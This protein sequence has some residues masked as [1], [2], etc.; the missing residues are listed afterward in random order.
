MNANDALKEKVLKLVTQPVEQTGFEIADI[1]LSRYRTQV[2]LRLYIYGPKGVTI[3]DCA[4]LSRLVGDI[5]D[6]TDLFDKG[7]LLEVSSPGLD[8][9]LTTARDFRY[10]VGETVRV[11]FVDKKKKVHGEILQANDTQVVL[12]VD[13]E[14][15]T[16]NLDEIKQAKIVL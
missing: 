12:R 3:D 10:R 6:E 15:I 13:Q 5:I 1:V 2:T 16:L 11:E 4:K 9:P 8:R 14:E 7:Y